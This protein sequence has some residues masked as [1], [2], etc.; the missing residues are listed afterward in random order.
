M[1]WIKLNKGWIPCGLYSCGF[2]CTVHYEQTTTLFT[3]P[4][5]KILPG[6]REW[7]FKSWWSSVYRGDRIY[8]NLGGN[9]PGY[10]E[11]VLHDFPLANMGRFH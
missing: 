1:I 10:G 7:R 2:Y 11:L 5:R 3:S 6:I 8:C 4:R 9:K